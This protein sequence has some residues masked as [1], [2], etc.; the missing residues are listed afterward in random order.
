[1][2]IGLKYLVQISGKR[3]KLKNIGERQPDVIVVTKFQ[4]RS[5]FDFSKWKRRDE[6]ARAGCSEDYLR[7]EHKVGYKSS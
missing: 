5:Q 3:G 2:V 6:I 1:M 7:D 4:L